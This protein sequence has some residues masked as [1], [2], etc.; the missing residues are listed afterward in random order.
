M[1]QRLLTNSQLEDLS[2]Q[3]HLIGDGEIPLLIRLLWD[4]RKF[5]EDLLELPIH[6]LQLFFVQV[7]DIDFSISQEILK[8]CTEKTNN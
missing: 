1:A 7:C 4:L 5:Q 3:H 2:E 8:L 6:H